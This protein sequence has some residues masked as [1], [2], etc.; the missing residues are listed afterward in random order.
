MKDPKLAK[1]LVKVWVH[2]KE[3]QLVQQKESL[4]LVQQ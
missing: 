3:K 1:L 2:W 4:L